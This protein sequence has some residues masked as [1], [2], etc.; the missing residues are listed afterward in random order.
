VIYNEFRVIY[1]FVIEYKQLVLQRAIP[2]R[3]AEYAVVIPSDV[4]RH[5]HYRSPAARF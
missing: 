2:P 3:S 5:T 1:E 4:R